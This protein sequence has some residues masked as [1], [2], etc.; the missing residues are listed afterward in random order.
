MTMKKEIALSLDKC[1]GISV[2]N[3]IISS[4]VWHLSS[5]SFTCLIRASQS[6]KIVR[7]SRSGITSLKEIT[8]WSFAYSNFFFSYYTSLSFQTFFSG[9]Q[10]VDVN[11]SFN[12]SSLFIIII[13]IISFWNVTNVFNGFFTPVT[14]FLSW[15]EV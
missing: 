9:E 5:F 8:S 1:S 10:S 13:H 14:P 3:W 12:F 2:S 7:S 15:Y 4:L 6:L 11:V